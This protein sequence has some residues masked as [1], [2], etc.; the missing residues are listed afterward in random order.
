[1]REGYLAALRDVK[2]ADGYLS[3]VDAP[4]R[5]E[6]VQVFQDGGNMVY[7]LSVQA[8]SQLLVEARVTA[9]GKLIKENSQ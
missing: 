6:A 1:M 3:D 7:T 9:V 8:H 2:L 4:L 5:I